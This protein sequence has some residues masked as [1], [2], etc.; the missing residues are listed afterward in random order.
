MKNIYEVQSAN[1]I[2]SAV[3]IVSFIAFVTVAVYV[4]TKAYGLYIGYEPGGLGFAGIALIIS[5]ITSFIS[6]YFSDKIVL[7]ISGARP[8][9]RSNDF[10]FF[11]AA[12]CLVAFPTASI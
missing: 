8:A 12:C 3:I 7:G 4:L 10:N 11:T 6:Y 1:K 9:N 5:G 2:K